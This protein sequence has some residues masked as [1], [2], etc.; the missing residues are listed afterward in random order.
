[1]TQAGA[2]RMTV[3]DDRFF[4]ATVALLLRPIRRPH[5]PM[6]PRDLQ[7][8]TPQAHPTG[9]HCGPHQVDRQDQAMQEGKAWRALQKLND[10]RTRVETL[11]VRPQQRLPRGAGNL[12]HR[13]RLALMGLALV[14]RGT[15]QRVQ[16]VRGDPSVGCDPRCL[17]APRGFLCPQ[18]PPFSPFAFVSIMAKD[19]EV[20]FWL[21][22][23]MESGYGLPGAVSKTKWPPR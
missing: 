21:P 23:F 22:P 18:R 19:G 6:E 12:T 7:E 10:H 3:R 20:A 17:V 13:G 11:L 1:V 16:P 9:T 2:L 15:A 5:K 8:Q 4:H 14:A